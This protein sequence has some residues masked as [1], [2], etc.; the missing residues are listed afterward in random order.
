MESIIM[1]LESIK[2]STFR[3]WNISDMYAWWSADVLSSMAQTSNGTTAVS[4]NNDPVAYWSD[5]LNGYPLIQTTNNNRPVYITNGINSLPSLSFD[6]TND[7]LNATSGA[8]CDAV[9][10]TGGFTAI[11]VANL[12]T[13]AAGVSVSFLSRNGSN[14]QSRFNLT[15]NFNTN[16]FFLGGRRQETDA[17]GNVAGLNNSFTPGVTCIAAGVA[18]YANSDGY[19]YVN[20]A[21]NATNTSWLT[22]GLTTDSAS[23]AVS[24][25]GLPDGA[26]QQLN[27]KIAQVLWF[28]RALSAREI[29]F[30]SKW[31]GNIYGVNI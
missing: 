17:I 9:R 12:T 29:L 5:L 2:K 18:D 3:P 22:N 28:K 23:A 19:L 8:V 11:V 25:G 27:G 16:G 31:L 24:V 20:G 15:A 10:N 4:A 1:L 21:L 14:A 6:G 26:T 13:S 7:N 30:A